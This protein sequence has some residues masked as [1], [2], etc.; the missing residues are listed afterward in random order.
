MNKISKIFNKTKQNTIHKQKYNF[1]PP[2]EN[3]P[4]YLKKLIEIKEN[5]NENEKNE[6]NEIEIKKFISISLTE[7]N[8]LFGKLLDGLNGYILHINSQ[9]LISNHRTNRLLNELQNLKGNILVYVRIRPPLESLNEKDNIIK[10]FDDVSMSIEGVKN[11][12]MKPY[13]FDRCFNQ[14]N[15]QND[16]FHEMEYLP[17][18]ILQGYNVSILAYGQTGSGKTYTMFGTEDNKGLNF[19][20]TDRLFELIQRSDNKIEIGLS[21]LEIYNE[22]VYDLLSNNENKITIS[23]QGIA[24]NTDFQIHKKEEIEYYYNVGIVQRSTASTAANEHSSR[25]HCITIITVKQ[26]D[27]DNNIITGKLYLVDLAGSER[28]SKSCV[29]GDRLEETKAI[30]KSLTC[31]SN[32]LQAL[33]KKDPHIPYRDSKLTFLLKDSLSE[34]SKTVLLC[35]LCPTQA[36]C[37]ETI[38]TLDFATRVKHIHFGVAKKH[39]EVQNNKSLIQNL[40]NEK[41]DYISR[42][43][44]YVKKIS[45]LETQ[46]K[47][48]EEWKINETNNK[49]N[50]IKAQNEKYEQ[51]INDITNELKTCKKDLDKSNKDIENLNN[52]INTLNKSIDNY[53]KQEKEYKKTIEE[54]KNGYNKEIETFHIKEKTY[55]EKINQKENEIKQLMKSIKESEEKLLMKSKENEEKQVKKSSPKRIQQTNDRIKIINKKSVQQ[56]SP[57]RVLGKPVKRISDKNLKIKTNNVTSDQYNSPTPILIDK[58]NFLK[59]QDIRSSLSVYVNPKSNIPSKFENSVPESMVPLT[60][61]TKSMLQKEENM[62]K[63]PTPLR[64]KENKIIHPHSQLKPPVSTPIKPRT[65]YSSPLNSKHRKGYPKSQNQEEDQYNISDSPLVTPNGSGNKNFNMLKYGDLGIVD[66]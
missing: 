63:P 38:S 41:K 47:K 1:N 45:E 46:I 43:E 52:N 64:L 3:L 9:L 7:Y 60:I 26:T 62:I 55:D 5:L 51:K 16:I 13:E 40:Q 35:T 10:I 50:G 57:H 21:M 61:N 19:K 33:D 65:V 17:Y 36:Q 31:L 23:D 4:E 66:S 15:T 44:S 42:E 37:N 8:K 6:K 39:I 18:S 11:N 27:K 56:P 24:G 48:L 2:K 49:N 20:L 53:K 30:N 34:N 32:V 58:K 25:S 29:D 28:L 59:D 14:Y 22:N 54:L 12:N